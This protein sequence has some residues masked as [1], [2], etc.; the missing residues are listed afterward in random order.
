[1]NLPREKV[2]AFPK[3]LRSARRCT[4]SFL[5]AASWARSACVCQFPGKAAGGVAVSSRIQQRDPLSATNLTA[6][7]PNSRLN[8]RLVISTLQSRGRDPVFMPTK[9]A[10]VHAGTPYI[11]CITS[12]ALSAGLMIEISLNC[13][14]QT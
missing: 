12:R 6:S 14:L 10:A 9:R 8:L 5:S 3:M 7:I 1:M 13:P 4:A 2:A 11:R